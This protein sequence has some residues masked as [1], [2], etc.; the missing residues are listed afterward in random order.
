VLFAIAASTVACN[1][2]TAPAT[3]EGEYRFAGCAN[4]G[5]GPCR[6]EGSSAVYYNVDSGRII[7]TAPS[8]ARWVMFYTHNNFGTFTKSSEDITGTF[9]RPTAGSVTVAL[10]ESR[11]ETLLWNGA[12]RLTWPRGLEHPVFEKP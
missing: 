12:K 8:Q 2:R 10:S 5:T 9:E 1:G 11:T 7:L 3:P 6:G 4:G